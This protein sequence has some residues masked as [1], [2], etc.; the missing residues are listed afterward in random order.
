M[1][2]PDEQRDGEN[3]RQ[4][5]TVSLGVGWG[6]LIGGPLRPPPGVITASPPTPQS[7]Q[8]SV[9]APLPPE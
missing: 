4:Q 7:I 3:P 8:L 5:S 9:V 1:R 2:A 6:Y